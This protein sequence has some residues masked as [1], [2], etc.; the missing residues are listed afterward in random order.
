MARVRSK[1]E[2][3]DKG[4]KSAEPFTGDTIGLHDMYRTNL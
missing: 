1:A 4:K 3:L 2:P